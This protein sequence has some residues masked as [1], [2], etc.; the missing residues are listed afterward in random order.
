MVEMHYIR[1]GSGRP[2][3]LL[4][5]LGGGWREWGPV[6]DGLAA[7]REV[8]A[9]DLPGFGETP[10]LPGKVSIETLADALTGF[11]KAHDL[12][13]VDVV[14]G[15]MGARLALELARRGVVGATVSLDPGGFWS[16]WQ[17]IYFFTSIWLSIR[18][19]RLLQ[20]A[21]PRLTASRIGRTL[22]FAQFSARPWRLSPEVTLDEMTSFVAA[23]SLDELLYG[24]V[25]GSPQKGAQP[26]SM[27]GP[28]MIG[29]GRKDRVCFPGQARKALDL[30][31]DASLH[32]FDD[33]GHLPYWDVPG[34]ATRL[35]LASTGQGNQQGADNRTPRKDE[36]A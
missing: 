24:L 5:G 30:F 17:K 3:L 25:Y 9:V 33:S 15:S 29:W 7:E 2:V 35:I 26:G 31:P 14:G 28:V 11:L 8:I 21:M 20:P 10:P 13:G 23:T 6:L 34:E 16:G 18:L 36:H 1:R 4:H 32:W 27:R 12:L 22:L 19:I